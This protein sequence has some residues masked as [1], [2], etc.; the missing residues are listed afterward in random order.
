MKSAIMVGV[1][2][3]W[4]TT[5]AEAH[6][7]RV[8]RYPYPQHC[9]AYAY[10]P[11]IHLPRAHIYPA[12][13]PHTHAALVDIPLPDMSAQWGG[14]MDTQLELSLQRLKVLRQLTQ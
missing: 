6:C 3:S 12:V 9:R 10:A 11:F 14:A 1:L 8:W 13:L 5:P 7:Y 2:L 4:V